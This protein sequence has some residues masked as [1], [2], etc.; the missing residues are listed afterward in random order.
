MAASGRSRLNARVRA[1]GG[2]VSPGVA[3]TRRAGR[4][5]EA[6]LWS[7]FGYDTVC[8]LWGLPVK[9][10]RALPESERHA[11]AR[12]SAYLDGLPPAEKALLVAKIRGA[13][14][15]D[16]LARFRR[17]ARTL[18]T[19]KRNGS[20]APAASTSRSRPRASGSA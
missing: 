6:E 14:P 9:A 20:R 8:L 11:L 18:P 13:S 17:M 15:A 4:D 2:R 1:P 3:R 10:V 7:T 16:R 5:P 12:V 19:A